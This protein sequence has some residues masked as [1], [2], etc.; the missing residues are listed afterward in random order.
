MTVFIKCPDGWYFRHD[1]QEV[2]PYA[3]RAEAEEGRRGLARF[4]KYKDTPGFI[5]SDRIQ[6]Q[7]PRR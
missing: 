3:T 7:R 2:G 4:E 5:T 1:G 6:P